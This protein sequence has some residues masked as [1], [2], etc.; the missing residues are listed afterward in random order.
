MKY[1]LIVLWALLLATFSAFAQGG[2]INNPLI[3]GTSGHTVPYLDGTNTWTNAQTF[4]T[5]VSSPIY[6]AAGILTFQSNGSTFAGLINTT[7]QWL[8]GTNTTAPVGGTTTGPTLTVTRNVAA[9]PAVSAFDPIAQFAAADGNSTD[10]I[11][12]SFGTAKFGA[13][14]FAHS[15]GTA[16][17]RTPTQATDNIGGAFAYGF[18]NNTVATY[19]PNAGVIMIA[20]D[21]FTNT[22]TGSRLD[23]Y[24]TPTGTASLAIGASVGAG[25]MI[26][27][28][29]D[30][31]AGSGQFN[32]QFFIPNITTSSAAQ[33]G[34]V[35][36]TTGTGK[37]TV[38]TTVGCLTSLL[39]A[40]DI[41]EHLSPAKA[42][43]IIT[44][45]DPFTFRYK[46]GWGDSGRYEQFGL[47]AEQVALVDER[48]IGR[49]PNG[50]LQGVRYQE[51]TAVLTG[52]IQELKHKND[53]LTLCNSN[54][55]C[56]IFGK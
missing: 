41:T 54:W 48:L 27:T 26:G 42:L 22:T 39:T 16:A 30:P 5:S 50:E 29:T 37:F 51:L 25:L 7:Q 1:I 35:C 47:G 43:S 38:D 11:L 45:L 13:V 12:Q 6:S 4:S 56:R 9:L 46:Q 23:L 21:N 44:K 52:A 3:T 2:G 49:D 8:M 55:R 18:F 20:T 53:E 40:K 36:W 17:S 28:T 32:A 34:T 24:A 10:F 19:T 15:R 33:T 31:G 14:R